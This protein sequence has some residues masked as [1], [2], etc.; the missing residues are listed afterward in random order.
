MDNIIFSSGRPQPPMPR[1]PKPSRSPESISLVKTFLRALPKG[2]EDWDD[3]APRTQEQIEQLRLDLTLSKLVREGRA[4]MK[5]K[6]LLQSFAEEHAALLR[7][8]ESQI[9]SFVFIA[10]GD[11]AIKSDL[12]VREVDEM[13]MAYTGAQRSAVRTLRLGVRRWIKASDTLRQSWLPRADELPL[14]RKSFIHIMKKIPDEDIGILR[15]M[16]VEGD[17][18]VLADVKVYIPKKQLSS[19]SLR[20]P[21][22]IHELH[23]GKLR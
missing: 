8:L 21:N 6:A 10:L 19:S 15:E 22:I 17:Q 1:Q 5:P 7:D 9:H 3:K 2:E 18:A 16:T 14:R 20:I 4:K 11:V 23:G 13:T 12:P